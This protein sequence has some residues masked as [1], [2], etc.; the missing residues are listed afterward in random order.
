MTASRCF[1]FEE[2]FTA[3]LRCIPM[4][5]RRKLDL[6]GVKLRL[7]HW[8]ALDRQERQRL[9]DWPDQ[10]QDVQALRLWLLERTA[11]LPEGPA[12][13]LPQAIAE[14]WQQQDCWPEV[15]LRSAEQ[16]GLA[17]RPG[18]WQTLE[19]LQRFALVKLSHPGHEHRNLPL[20]LGEFDLIEP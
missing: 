15:V 12:R 5:V 8:T 2:D 1:R 16:L 9:L 20:A 14:P 13:C 18:G 19:E 11:A 7:A 10:E 3:S 4:A 6:A 17:L